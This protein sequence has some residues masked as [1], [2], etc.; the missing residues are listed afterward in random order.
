MPHKPAGQRTAAQ[1]VLL[2]AGTFPGDFTEWDLTVACHR[3]FPE[4]FTMRGYPQYPDHKLVSSVIMGNKPQTP[5]VLGYM[6]RVAPSTYRVTD[7]GRAE[8]ARLTSDTP[9]DDYTTIRFVLDHPDFLRWRETQERPT[10]VVQRDVSKLL[11]T[12]HRHAGKYLTARPGTPGWRSPIAPEQI[13]EGLAFLEV[14]GNGIRRRPLTGMCKPGPR[15]QS[16]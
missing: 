14:L 1:S 11:A 3:Q 12:F 15:K 10:T 4:R 9:D 2:A 6:K 5:L 8:L 16:A 7:L 13:G